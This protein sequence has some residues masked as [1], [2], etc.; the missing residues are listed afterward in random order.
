MLNRHHMP[1]LLGLFIVAACR[2]DPDASVRTELTSIEDTLIYCEDGA[3]ELQPV[4]TGKMTIFN[5]SNGNQQTASVTKVEFLTTTLTCTGNAPDTISL[6]A[7]PDN[8]IRVTY[9][10]GNVTPLH[11]F[12]QLAATL[13]RD[14]PTVYPDHRR[15][16]WFG[17]DKTSPTPKVRVVLHKREELNDTMADT[18][19]IDTLVLY[20]A[21]P[22]E[23]KNRLELRLEASPPAQSE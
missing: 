11:G 13:E 6:A 22:S 2:A 4:F 8:D 15:Y 3:I 10:Q 12:E 5:A 23:N 19:N 1:L 9:N 14:P 7:S 18:F 17:D 16:T 20:D 21:Y